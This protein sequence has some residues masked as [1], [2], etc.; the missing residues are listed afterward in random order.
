MIPIS[1][2]FDTWAA[3]PIQPPIGSSNVDYQKII[4]RNLKKS[5]GDI[6]LLKK[7]NKES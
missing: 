3:T 1:S 2:L 4:D 7:K 6:V 5:N